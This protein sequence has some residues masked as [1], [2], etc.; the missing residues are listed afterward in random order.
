LMKMN[1]PGE[2]A[3]TTP[4]ASKYFYLVMKIIIY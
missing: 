1:M 2:W 4:Y 3:V